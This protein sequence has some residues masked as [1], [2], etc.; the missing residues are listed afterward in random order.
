LSCKTRDGIDTFYKKLRTQIS[1]VEHLNTLWPKSWFNVKT[2]LEKMTADY[3]SYDRYE[4]ICRKEKISGHDQQTTLVDFLNDLGVILHF[5]EPALR[6]TNVINPRWITEAVYE[7][8]NSKTLAD[9]KGSL[10][11]ETL[12]EILDSN[13]YPPQKHG[14]IIELMKKFE[15]CYNVDKNTVL[16]PDLLEV[17]EPDFEFDD[18]NCL[19]FYLS[20]DF[21]PKSVMARFIVKRSKEIKNNLRWRSGV[22]LENKS[23]DSTAVVKVDE[24]DKKILILVSG[25]MKRDWFA[26]LR[27]TFKEINGSFEKL[28]VDEMVPL[29]GNTNAAV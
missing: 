17:A 7:I 8:I 16:L 3:I 28:D 22:V 14:Y 24:R 15:L 11:I 19:K 5:N 4:E 12:K 23:L 26:V 13:K 29:P 20:Y 27:H 9:N 6:E 21:L 1:R 10:K 25:T 18:S 2:R